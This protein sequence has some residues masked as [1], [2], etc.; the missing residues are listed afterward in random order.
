MN[1]RILIAFGTRPELIKLWPVAREFSNVGAAHWILL[2]CAG[3]HTDLLDGLIPDPLIRSAITLKHCHGD[4]Q[5]QALQR[6]TAGIERIIREHSSL[7]HVIVQGDTN[8][9]LAA[10]VAAARCGLCIAHVEAGLRSNAMSDP[11]P[12]E[13]NRTTISALASL[14]FAPTETA[15]GNLLR[16]GIRPDRILTTGNTSM[17]AL[18]LLMEDADH[19]PRDH[20]ERCILVV[21]HRTGSLSASTDQLVTELLRVL[22]LVADLEVKWILHPNRLGTPSYWPDHACFASSPPLSMHHFAELMER[23]CVV[24]TD[25]GGVQEEA[26]ALGIPLVV[27]RRCHERP[28]SFASG[29]PALHSTEPR[30]I[31]DFILANH[32]HRRV[33]SKIFGDGLAA[34]HIVKRILADITPEQYGAVFI[35]GGPAGTGPLFAA[36]KEGS[37]P[38]LLANGLAVVERSKHL[39]RG[40]LSSHHVNSDT[41]ADVFLEC[42]NGEAGATL[43]IGDMATLIEPIRKHTGRSIPLPDLDGYLLSIGERLEHLVANH[44]NCRVA[45]ER[46]VELVQ[47]TRDAQWSIHLSGEAGP[48]IATNVLLA[49]GAMHRSARNKGLAEIAD[50]TLRGSSEQLLHGQLDE[51]LTGTISRHTRIRIVGS[52]HSGFSSAWYLLNRFG[53]RIERPG[54]IRIVGHARPKIFFPSSAEALSIG[55]TDHGPTDV[56]PITGR[57]YRLAGLRMDGRSLYLRMLGLEGPR[58]DRVV[59]ELK[60]PADTDKAHSTSDV[61]I[62]ATG[63]RFRSVPLVNERMEP[64]ALLGEHTGHWVDERCR[65]LDASGIALPGLYAM[66][67]ATG[68]IPSGAL[69]GEPSFAAQTN[70]LWYYQ[71]SLGAIIVNELLHADPT[72]LP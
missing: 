8:S 28:E 49:T 12:E 50:K 26:T 60:D 31:A 16:E 72:G 15:R 17:D 9:A 62:D 59:L 51:L 44:V 58:E 52:S 25:S 66:G 55:Y 23:A 69:G 64:I 21:L 67:L 71:N 47:R 40:A 13:I 37:L 38:Q 34:G 14:H 24:I 54:A 4:G 45:K 22:G 2:V 56:C 18:R 19:T 65:L 42:L 57:L 30:D 10:A 27:F 46:T 7:T 5:D 39:V 3:Q 6:M 68:Y 63:Y 43:G 11:Y 29:A 36:L 61:E 48:M 33:R 53:E 35:G 70:G 20:A 41:V 1:P 32:Q